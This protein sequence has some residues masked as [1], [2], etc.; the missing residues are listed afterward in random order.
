MEMMGQERLH[1]RI[2]K[3]SFGDLHSRALIMLMA[4]TSCLTPCATWAASPLRFLAGFF[5]SRNLPCLPAMK[6]IF[7]QSSQPSPRWGI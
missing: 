6:E 5:M 7:F 3:A 2:I 4:I 1:A